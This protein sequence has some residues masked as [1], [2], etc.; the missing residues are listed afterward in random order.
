MGTRLDLPTAA[1]FVQPP[2]PDPAIAGA[3]AGTRLRIRQVS[4]QAKQKGQEQ[5][6]A[7]QRML[8]ADVAPN[9]TQPSTVAP[10]VSRACDDLVN[11]RQLLDR[12]VD[13]IIF[14]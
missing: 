11:K 9:P 10:M 1:P 7:M 13:L 8:T 6:M 4:N 2:A 3:T 12:F 5:Q 14:G